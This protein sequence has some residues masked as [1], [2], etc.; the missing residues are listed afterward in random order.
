MDLLLYERVPELVPLRTSVLAVQSRLQRLDRDVPIDD[1]TVRRWYKELAD[2]FFRLVGMLVKAGHTEQLKA[3][4]HLLQ[5]RHK[6]HVETLVVPCP[7]V[8]RVEL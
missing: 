8:G 7:D 4:K 6:L 2:Q 1:A 5:E 3:M